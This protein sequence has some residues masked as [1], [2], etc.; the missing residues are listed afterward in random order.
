MNPAGPGQEV[1]P[2]DRDS[3]RS[4]VRVQFNDEDDIQGEAVIPS[5]GGTVS[6]WLQHS[7]G[8]GV[9]DGIITPVRKTAKILNIQILFGLSIFFGQVHVLCGRML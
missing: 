4:R 8:V 6:E 7:L 9:G 5:L 3:G 2:D 1:M